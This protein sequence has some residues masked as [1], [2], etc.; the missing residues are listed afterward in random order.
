LK[1]GIPALRS[2]NFRFFLAGQATSLLGNSVQQ[3]ALVWLVYRTSHSAMILGLMGF[4]AGFPAAIISIFAGV[5]ADRHNPHR[6]II[7]TQTLSTLQALLLAGLVFLNHVTVAAMVALVCLLGFIN[8]VDTPVRQMLV[9]RLVNRKE[10]ISSAVASNSIVYDLARIFGPAIGG[11]ILAS[12]T[13]AYSFVVNGFTHAVVVGLF[14]SIRLPPHISTARAEPV[15][16]TFV[17]GVRYAFK[18]R[19]VRAIIILSA[20]ISFAGSTYMV[21]MPVVAATTL[22]GGP[23]ML[24]FLMGSVGVG[25][26][27]GGLFFSFR[28]RTE[29]VAPLIAIGASLFGLG[30]FAF[31]R[32][33]RP[34]ISLLALVVVGWG[35]MVM[36]ASCNTALLTFTDEQKHGRVLS[37]FSLSYLTMSPVG[38]LCTGY[39]ANKLGT[40]TTITVG[41]IISLLAAA[42]FSTHIPRLRQILIARTAVQNEADHG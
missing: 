28:F 3:V 42:W 17:E 12:Y 15:L 5:F 36:M 32:S 20:C 25:A 27:I 7:A 23:N 2:R 16:E 29:W 39:V 4:V 24:G 10:D 6:I 14:L 19:E 13:E 40:L 38:A 33:S 31:S 35:I 18:F 37:L 9:A 30:L 21:L 8:G 11:F 34:I 26:I 41:A 1:F 22:K